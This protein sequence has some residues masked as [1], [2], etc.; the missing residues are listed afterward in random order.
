MKFFCTSVV[1]AFVY[2]EGD[3]FSLLQQQ[4]WNVRQINIGEVV[5]R[6]TSDMPRAI[7]ATVAEVDEMVETFLKDLKETSIGLMQVSVS[8][9]GALLRRA[10]Q[11]EEVSSFI[12]G[13]I[14]LPEETKFRVLNSVRG[15]DDLIQG[16]LTFPEQDRRALLMQLG[17]SHMDETVAEKTKTTRT[18]DAAG[19]KKT[20]TVTDDR[21]GNLIH[22]HEH[23][24]NAKTGKTETT[25]NSKN[26]HVHRHRFDGS[27]QTW[28][29]TESFDKNG[30]KS[31]T[32]M[33]GHDANT[34]HSRTE[35]STAN[36]EFDY[37]H[38]TEAKCKFCFVACPE[39]GQEDYDHVHNEF[40]KGRLVAGEVCGSPSVPVRNATSEIP[41]VDFLYTFG[42]V[43]VGGLV[44]LAADDKCFPGIRFYNEDRW[45]GKHVFF[46]AVDLGAAVMTQTHQYQHAR[47]SVV[48]LQ[49]WKPSILR[50]CNA[51]DSKFYKAQKWPSLGI[52]SNRLH[53]INGKDNYMDRLNRIIDDASLTVNH[54]D[55]SRP[56]NEYIDLLNQGAGAKVAVF[57][58]RYVY[59][60][61]GFS[62]TYQ[63]L[64][65]EIGSDWDIV[66][67]GHVLSNKD[68]DHLMLM[69]HADTLDCA[70]AFQGT[71]GTAELFMVWNAIKTCYCGWS[72]H[73]GYANELVHIAKSDVYARLKTR[74][75]KCNKLTV[76]GHSLGG[77]L[78]EIFAACVNK[79]SVAGTQFTTLTWVKETPAAMPACAVGAGGAVPRLEEVAGGRVYCKEHTDP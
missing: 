62:T 50:P 25:T 9:K 52:Q 47:M 2:G 16:F 56:H 32:H 24:H 36:P 38:D 34:G 22:S 76:T 74:L 51:Q 59:N 19:N 33:H 48:S 53:S 13:Y 45:D 4:S 29:A 37:T 31:H 64:Q 5:H 66:F 55:L 43:A 12:E 71:K 41:Q 68:E 26:R 65:K 8:Q 67:M 23:V 73:S 30:Q 79:H 69:Q 14:N 35:S 39:C 40:V 17:S 21:H 15:S 3:Y 20:K 63:G 27:G 44:N 54:Q 78:A 70:L 1:V 61:D 18:E 60:N 75:G 58:S 11:S 46:H 6:A 57:L 42:A 77:A 72:V 28:S 7:D 10:S 49:W